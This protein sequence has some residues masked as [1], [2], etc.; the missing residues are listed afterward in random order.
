METL[1]KIAAIFQEQ[2]D[3]LFDK[4]EQH[5]LLFIFIFYSITL[6]FHLYLA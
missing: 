2:T 3:K 5:K 6:G 1:Q 4:L